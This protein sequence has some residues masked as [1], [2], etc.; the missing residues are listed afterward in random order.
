MMGS[1]DRMSPESRRQSAPKSLPLRLLILGTCMLLGLPIAFAA[2]PPQQVLQ[3]V[4]LVSL[5][6]PRERKYIER[7]TA[8]HVGGG[9]FRTAAHVV[10]TPLPDEYQGKGYDEWELSLAN[11]FGNPTFAPIGRAEVVCVDKRWTRS[12]FHDVLPHDSALF[13]LVTGAAPDEALS[14]SERRPSTG[15]GVSTWG[16]PLG[17]IL[18]E[19]KGQV[20]AV[21]D[22]WIMLE[23]LVNA[24]SLG[25]YS[26]SPVIDGGGKVVGILVAAV[27]GVGK[28]A[29]AVPIHDAEGACAIPQ[30]T[31]QSSR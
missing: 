30:P 17:L 22:E 14:A 29:L 23:G 24:P 28:P 31:G 4:V 9:W 12:P 6:S 1:A 27:L 21:S 7:G 5:G 20:T 25:G 16:F 2:A 26:G 3:S 13:R 11:E 18:Y 8:F 10:K 15:E 19:A